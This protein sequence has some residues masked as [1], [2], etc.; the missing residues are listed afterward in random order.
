MIKKLKLS[1]VV[2]LALILAPA[3]VSAQ[4][5]VPH[6]FYGKASYSD[7][8][9]LADG[10]LVEVKIGNTTVAK[11]VVYKGAYGYN[12]Y[13]FFVTDPES[14]R[15]S[16]VLKFFVNG[17]D[18]GVT[19]TFKNGEHSKIDLTIPAPPVNSPPPLPGGNGGGGGGGGGGGYYPQIQQATST[20][21]STATTTVSSIN[22]SKG[23]A[24]SDN[25]ID[26]LDF[27]LLMVNW[28][29]A[30]SGNSADFN[31][32]GKVD[33]LDFNAMMIWWTV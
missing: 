32:D 27:N 30:N 21:T 26:V 33:L 19:E 20:T 3:I 14:S 7:G 31:S 1:A 17:V 23:D 6:Q 5:A 22:K 2:L 28:G 12:P 11:T 13:W 18:T 15:A 4:P 9:A 24:N 29:N 10:T 8:S 16:S 25:K